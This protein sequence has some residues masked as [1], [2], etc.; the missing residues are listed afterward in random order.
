MTEII[1]ETLKDRILRSSRHILAKEGYN[2]L[3]M[4]K[5][6]SSVDCKAASIYHH[7]ANKD[8]IVHALI[9]EGYIMQAEYIE[10]QVIGIESP[11]D[12]L[13]IRARAYIDFGLNYPEY[14]NIMYNLYS[15]ELERY[16]KENYRR[17][18]INMFRN[19]DD[20]KEA[21][22]LGLVQLEEDPKILGNAAAAMLHGVVT[23]FLTQRFHVRL[24]RQKI[25]DQIVKQVVSM[26]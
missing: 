3:S 10:N 23:L 21:H 5:I 19:I 25:I 18:T 13:E 17:N 22:R 12:R 6:A 24:D 4:R 2:G 9:D 26:T 1:P 8:K 7:F 15:S 20:I 11:V 16:P 14:Y